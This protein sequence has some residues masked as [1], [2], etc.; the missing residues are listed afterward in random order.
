[1]GGCEGINYSG[2]VRRPTR[3]PAPTVGV[4]SELAPLNRDCT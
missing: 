4:G 1:M 2:L 3:Y